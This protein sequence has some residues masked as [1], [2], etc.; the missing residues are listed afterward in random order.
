[1]IFI[2]SFSRR[3]LAG[4]VFPVVLAGLLARLMSRPSLA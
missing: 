4:L 2:G 3:L 1:M